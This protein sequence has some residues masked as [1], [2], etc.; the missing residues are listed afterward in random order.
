MLV[1][2]VNSWLYFLMLTARVISS[3]DLYC[4]F[5]PQC[6]ALRTCRSGFPIAI[7]AKPAQ[8][9]WWAKYFDLRRA[10]VFCSGCWLLK[11]KMTRYSRNIGRHGT[12]GPY[13]FA[14]GYKKRIKKNKQYL[15]LNLPLTKISQQLKTARHC[16]TPMKSNCQ[17]W[18]LR[19]VVSNWIAEN[20]DCLLK[21]YMLVTSARTVSCELYMEKRVYNGLTSFG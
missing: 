15:M 5:L 10:T 17:Y 4:C 14:Y 2:L 7:R 6:E 11:H 20:R 18:M 12:L 16:R 3:G 21:L 8:N 9:F 19:L 13:V 1:N